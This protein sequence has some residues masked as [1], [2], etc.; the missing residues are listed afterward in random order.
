MSFLKRG[1]HSY[2]TTPQLRK[3]VGGQGRD[4]PEMAAIFLGILTH[5][6]A[7]VARDGHAEFQGVDGVE[8]QTFNEDRSLGIDRLWSDVFQI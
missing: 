6:D 1:R 8:P 3:D 7:P 2:I 5:V 4:R